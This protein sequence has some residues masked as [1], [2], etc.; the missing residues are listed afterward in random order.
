VDNI[1]KIEQRSLLTFEVPAWFVS[2]KGDEAHFIPVGVIQLI[3]KRE[4]HAF[5]F[6]TNKDIE[7]VHAFRQFLGAC[8]HSINIINSMVNLI[9]DIDNTHSVLERMLNRND[10]A[11]VMRVI[12]FENMIKNY[13]VMVQDINMIDRPHENLKQ[14]LKTMGFMEIYDPNTAGNPA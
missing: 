5:P 11:Q 6:V 2:T 13:Q 1:L 4:D 14:E 8:M 12:N 9:L 7:M 10:L 3:N